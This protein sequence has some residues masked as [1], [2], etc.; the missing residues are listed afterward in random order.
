MAPVRMLLLT[1]S[2]ALAACTPPAPPPLEVDASGPEVGYLADVKPVLDARCVVCHSCY[3]APC[4]LQLGS[5]EGLDRGGSKQAVYS[6]TRLRAQ[7]PT[8]LFTDA[9]G[10]EAW[11]EK[12]F[13]SVV[14]N[15][16][17]PGFDDSILLAL[18]DAKRREPLPEGEY[19][20]E[21]ADLVC[22][23]TRHELGGFLEQ[24]PNR[25]MP[26]GFPALTDREYA[27]L[28]T[29]LAQGRPG[30][31]AAEQRALTTPSSVA[32]GH[33][34]R[35][36]TFLNRSDPKHALTARY[37]YE[38][39]FLAHVRFPDAP[40]EFYELVRSTTPPGEPVA[41][42]ATVRPYDDPGVPRVF[43]RFR[44]IHATIVHKTHMVVD[45]DDA[46]L[47]RFRELF[48]EPEWAETP[49]PVDPGPLAAANPFLVYSQIPPISRYRFL[50]DDSEYFVRTFIR[51]PV[52]KGQVA[53]NVIHDHFWVLFRDPEHDPTVLDP[54]FLVEQAANLAL[55]DEEGSSERL[56]KAF[57]DAYRKR[58]KAF[59]RA[60]T[61]FYEANAPAD[62]F[63]LDA[64]W[65]GRRGEDSPMLTVYRHFD[66]ASVHKGAR[67]AL[68]R[69]LW[70]IDY[71][72]FERIYYALVAGFDVYGN[73]SHQANVRRYMDFLRVEGELNFVEFLPSEVRLPTVRSWYLGVDAVKNVTPE[74]VLGDIEAQV[75]YETD[76]PKRELVEK[77]VEG[78]LL[79]ETG[80][81]FDRINYDRYDD[82][83][84]AMPTSF[85]T[86]EDILNGFRALTAPGT[87]FIR[88][89][90][91]SSVNLIYVRVKDYQGSDR[92]FTIVVNRWHDN[93]NT[94]FGEAKQ[95]D[96][97]KDTIDFLPGT[98]GSYPNYFL[99]VEAADV[100][101]LFDMLENFDGSPAYVAKLLRYGVNR[102]DPRFWETYDW[103][104]QRLFEDDPRNAGLY[105][106][107][108]Y[109]PRAIA[110]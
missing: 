19:H 32:A 63:G 102:S 15:T 3:N 53:L 5:Y 7:E 54:S 59:Y 96:P 60:K 13:S 80:I 78:H 36:E 42:V 1:L 86:H 51:G 27:T 44:R 73:L 91:G 98:I 95:L 77:V 90:N 97:S 39:F 4:Q 49:H 79:P 10:T 41:V 94:M 99:V 21:A 6:A 17:A 71:S 108:R 8:R 66:S 92:V 65:K 100:P 61:D 9:H 30:P 18:L 67:G 69:T 11:R 55:P 43:Y 84:P 29:W 110:R 83:P 82:G 31:S 12:G 16:A 24:H 104:Q 47:A 93:V 38:H 76:D 62:A 107:N 48:I 88:H 72:Q 56:V 14:D 64:I 2:L 103:F 35:W 46:R 52:C 58:Y 81:A 50:L 68:P 106:L 34:E 57:S 109:H 26:F 70:V 37:L 20:P 85:E 75:A 45:F 40:D 74:D 87:E 101:D 22:P 105:D 25:G 89:Q 23:A 33:I 28:A